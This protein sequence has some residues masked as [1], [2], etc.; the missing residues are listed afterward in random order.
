MAEITSALRSARLRRGL[1][2]TEVAQL[3]RVSRKSVQ[4]WERGRWQPNAE[5]R[6]HLEALLGTDL[7]PTA[8]GA[9]NV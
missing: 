3:F 5:R 7:T 1:T 2:V 8:N 4:A 9:R 6:R